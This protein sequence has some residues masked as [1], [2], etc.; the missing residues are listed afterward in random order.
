[1]I[2]RGR[3]RLFA[4]S[5]AAYSART[6]D[7]IARCTVIDMLGL[8]TLDFDKL[9]RWQLRPQDFGEDDF[10]KLKNSGITIFHPAVGYDE[11]PYENCLRDMAGWRSFIA[12]HDRYFVRVESPADLN[13]AKACGKIGILVGEQ[14][15]A[16]FRSLQDVDRFYHLGQ[17]VSQL[18]GNV[19]NRIGSGASEPHDHGLTEFGAGIVGRM[20]R[21]GMAVDVSHCGDRTTL[22]AFEASVKPVLVTHSNCRSLAN[23]PRCKTDE[24]IRK[25]AQTGGVMGITLIRFFVRTGGTVTLEDA[26][27]HIDRVARLVGV[28]HAGIG[29]DVDLEGRNKLS[30]KTWQALQITRQADLDGIQYSS[31]IYD[32]T[33]GLVRRG[34]SDGCIELILG[35]NFQRALS[36]IWAAQP[37][38]PAA[39]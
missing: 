38:R 33:E 20:N 3:F 34:Y 24:A 1:M 23:H 30:P 29:T 35:G 8:L 17:R 32:I 21:L 36:E 28:E 37:P 2:N 27:D 39:A 7:L 13:R 22:D 9:Y 4:G 26:L 10:A 15:S 6:L 12:R 11:N 16:H 31:K 18:T 14:N 19:R 25:M 5:S